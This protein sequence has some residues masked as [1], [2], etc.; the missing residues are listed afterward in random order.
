MR[1]PLLVDPTEVTIR[2]VWG[3]TTHRSMCPGGPFVGSTCP[4][5]VVQRPIRIL[6]EEVRVSHE[7]DT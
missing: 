5:L 3:T 7:E 6:I 2:R 4:S 1:G